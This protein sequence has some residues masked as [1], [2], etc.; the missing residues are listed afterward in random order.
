MSVFQAV[1]LGPAPGGQKKRYRVSPAP[2]RKLDEEEAVQG[3]HLRRPHH[4]LLFLPPG[5][6]GYTYGCIFF[7]FFPLKPE[8]PPRCLLRPWCGGQALL[9]LLSVI[10]SC[11]SPGQI[12]LM[13][14]EAQP[15]SG[16]A[17]AIPRGW[18]GSGTRRHPR[19]RNL[20]SLSSPSSVCVCGQSAQVLV[21]MSSPAWPRVTKWTSVP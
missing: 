16:D 21:P 9:E 19:A 6:E 5:P 13:F 15:A 8:K 12:C 18:T 20:P 14:S 7:F 10:Q 3:P 1:C 4:E 17:A 11:W 2:C